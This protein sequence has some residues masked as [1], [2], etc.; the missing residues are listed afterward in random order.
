MGVFCY[1]IFSLLKLSQNHRQKGSQGDSSFCSFGVRETEEGASAVAVKRASAWWCV[2][3][4][5]DF[6]VV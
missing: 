5:W 2:D 6:P 4:P 3:A 1:I